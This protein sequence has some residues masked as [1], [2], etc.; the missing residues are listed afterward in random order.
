M[1]VYR[2]ECCS[3]R[4]VC[5]SLSHEVQSGLMV[6]ER[7]SMGAGR[8]ENNTQDGTRKQAEG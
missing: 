2:Q 1:T 7:L 8:T 5:L 4:G 3:P 6:S